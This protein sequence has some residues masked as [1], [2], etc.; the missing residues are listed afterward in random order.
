[1]H[2]SLNG[3]DEIVELEVEV[4]PDWHVDDTARPDAWWF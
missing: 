4:E 3:M 2:L 1:V